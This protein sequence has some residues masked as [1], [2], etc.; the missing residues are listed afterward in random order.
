MTGAFDSEID[1]WK[2]PIV[3]QYFDTAKSGVPYISCPDALRPVDSVPDTWWIIWAPGFD[4]GVITEG[5]RIEMWQSRLQKLVVFW[6]IALLLIYYELAFGGYVGLALISILAGIILLF[7]TSMVL[8]RSM[9]AS[10]AWV[11]FPA[12]L[13]EA[14]RSHSE[15]TNEKDKAS[16][17]KEALKEGAARIVGAAGGFLIEAAAGK[18]AG[19]ISEMAFEG[20]C[21]AAMNKFTSEEKI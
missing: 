13:T 3:R 9:F 6:F 14:L 17:K 15:S 12:E 7:L 10:R 1:D 19:K 16:R 11:A 5:Y 2:R 8:A 4:G 21:K 20:A 18:A